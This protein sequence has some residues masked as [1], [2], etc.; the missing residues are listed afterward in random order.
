MTDQLTDHSDPMDTNRDRLSERAAE[1][2]WQA[3]RT[4]EAR[5]VL[6]QVP[7]ADRLPLVTLVTEPGTTPDQALAMLRQVAAMT[8]SDRRRVLTLASSK[9]AR[10]RDLAKRLATEV[11]LLPDPRRAL[12]DEARVAVRKAILAFPNDAVVPALTAVLEDLVA[13]EVEIAAQSP[14]HRTT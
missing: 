10:D 13:I 12:L 11:S 1:R 9:D 5:E 8:A 2:G 6:D 14:V 4:R 3:V 7:A